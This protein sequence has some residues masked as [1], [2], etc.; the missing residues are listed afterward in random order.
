MQS[1]RIDKWLWAAR[2]HKTRALAQEALDRGQVQV[3]GTV[4]KPSREVRVGDRLRVVRHGFAVEM[5]LLGLSNQRGPAS[6]A[7][8]L[9]AQTPDNRVQ[10][11]AWLEARQRQQD[12]GAERRLG[13]PTKR[14]RRDL[15]HLRQGWGDRWQASWDE[16]S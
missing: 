8:Q 4:A 5:D 9:Y 11:A 13:R 2:W 16:G 6:Q 14:E 10:E 7:Q 12:P 1:M 15:D 3:N